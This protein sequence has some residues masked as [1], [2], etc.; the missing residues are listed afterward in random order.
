[1]Y[2]EKVW[3]AIGDQDLV[4]VSADLMLDGDNSRWR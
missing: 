3:A 2:E 4:G 1:L